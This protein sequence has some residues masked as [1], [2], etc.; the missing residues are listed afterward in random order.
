MTKRESSY[1]IVVRYW[2]S[3]VASGGR[4]TAKGAVVV[5]ATRPVEGTAHGTRRGREKRTTGT[6]PP[7]TL[8]WCEA[9]RSASRGRVGVS[10]VRARP[11][12]RAAATGARPAPLKEDVDPVSGRQGGVVGV[13]RYDGDSGG[14][15][16]RLGDGFGGRRRPGR[17]VSGVRGDGEVAL[18]GPVAAPGPAVRRPRRRRRRER[19]RERGSPSSAGPEA[20]RFRTGREG[21]QRCLRRGGGPVGRARPG[22]AGRTLLRP[23]EPGGGP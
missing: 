10:P 20:W 16:E 4:W 14:C 12:R 13:R 6:R 23:A 8:S 2:F 17:C 22:R 5:G 11:G 7:H 19:R 9:L 15:V 3:N 21:G 1:R 18:G